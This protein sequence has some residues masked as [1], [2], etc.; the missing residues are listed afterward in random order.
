MEARPVSD[1]EALRKAVDDART[2]YNDAWNR[3]R[4]I[5]LAAGDWNGQVPADLREAWKVQTELREALGQ[6]EWKLRDARWTEANAAYQ[7]ARAVARTDWQAV[8]KIA[9]GISTGIGGLGLRYGE[10]G[11]AIAKAKESSRV[12]HDALIQT[13]RWELL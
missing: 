6:A 3:A 13:R 7:Q 4:N 1:F 12:A 8:A 2:A 9:D 10:L 11:E 5:E